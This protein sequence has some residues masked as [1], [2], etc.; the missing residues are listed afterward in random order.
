MY[1]L[2]RGIWSNRSNDVLGVSCCDRKSEVTALWRF[3]NMSS[4]E[5]F[6]KLS[7]KFPR[8][9]RLSEGPILSHSSTDPYHIH[10]SPVIFIFYSQIYDWHLP[11]C[12]CDRCSLQSVLFISCSLYSCYINRPS[13]YP[14]IDLS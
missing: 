1:E 9:F 6:L 3:E 11:W 2:D 5:T 4:E 10:G 7:I 8:P 14:L 13:L 12:I